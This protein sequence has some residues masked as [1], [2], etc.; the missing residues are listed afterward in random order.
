MEISDHLVRRANKT[1]AKQDCCGDRYE[2]NVSHVC[3]CGFK[4]CNEC[5]RTHLMDL[6]MDKSL[7]IG[8]GI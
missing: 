2:C 7:H 5:M 6:H 8:E 1:E 4:G 3:S